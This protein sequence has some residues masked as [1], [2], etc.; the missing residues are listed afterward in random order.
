MSKYNETEEHHY[1]IQPS[2][3]QV[4]AVNIYINNNMDEMSDLLA[5][6]V[7]AL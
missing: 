6:L 3:R 5:G 1:L 4:A 7:K 2:Y